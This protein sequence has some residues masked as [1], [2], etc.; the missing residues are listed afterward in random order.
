[1][2]SFRQTNIKPKYEKKLSDKGNTILN[3]YPLGILLTPLEL[4]YNLSQPRVHLSQD[5]S[6]FP[7]VLVFVIAFPMNQVLL[8]ILCGPMIGN[9]FNGILNFFV[10]HW[11]LEFAKILWV[12]VVVFEHVWCEDR[13]PGVLSGHVESKVSVFI[14]FH[15]LVGS[16]PDGLQFLR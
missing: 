6:R 8:T 13:V 16:S 9:S 7:S 12:I 11:E 4:L 10:V 15:D 2:T 1:M 3:P 14:D 5:L